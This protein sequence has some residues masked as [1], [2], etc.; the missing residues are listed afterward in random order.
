[1]KV[2]VLGGGNEIGA[3]CLHI[4]FEE[5]SI[6]IDAGMRMH[7]E[8]SL[9]MFG[10]LDELSKPDIV[11][12]THAHADHI[13]ALPVIHAMYPDVPVYSTPPTADLMQIMMKDS[14]K[15]LTEQS[16]LTESLVP[17]TEEQMNNFLQQIRVFPANGVL[18]IAGVKITSYRAGHIVGAVMF[19]IE[20]NGER[21]LVTG[22]L[23][24]N[25][26]RTIPGAKVADDIRPDVVVMESTYGNRLHTDR[27]TE[28]K[29]LAENVAATIENGG[30]ALIPAFAIG[31]AQ[32]IL[33]ILQAYMEKGLIPTFPIYVDGLVTPVCRVYKNYPHYLKGPVAHR[34]R[35]NGDAFLTEGRCIAVDSK[36]RNAIV[37]G[38]PAC[39]VAS[40]GMLTGGA[41]AW[42]ARHL[43]T[44]E[45]NAVYLTGY[46]DEESPG[47]KLLALAE[48]TENTLDIDG[49]TYQVKCRVDKFGLSAHADASE[50][51]R[52]IET[53]EPTYTLLVHGDD[54]ARI[55]LIEK[56]HP[57]FQPVLT[58]NGETY[59]FEKR[60]EK[61]GIVG[62]RY[63]RN[64]EQELLRNY[65][66]S[67]LLYK[68][69]GDQN[70]K[71][72]LCQ[73][74]HPK[75]A[76]LYCETPKGKVDKVEASSVA[77]TL[78]PWN[79]SIERYTAVA[80]EVLTFSRPYLEG[81]NWDLL[82]E[83]I[84][85]LQEI[86]QTLQVTDE[87]QQFA[88]AIA[89]QSIP[90]ECRHVDLEGRVGYRLDKKVKFKL[91]NLDLPIQA[92]KMNPNHAMDH[93]RSYFT[94]H[95]HFLRCGVQQ[96]G[97]DNPHIL[98]S[99]DFP[100]SITN[101]ERKRVIKDI[102]KRTGWD[103]VF[104]DSVRH[105]AFQPVLSSLLGSDVDMPS[106]HINQSLVVTK[107]PKPENSLEISRKFN[108][109]TGFALR[110][111]EDHDSVG[112]NSSSTE[113]FMANSD[114]EPME[115]NQ[116]IAI[117][118]QYGEKNNVKIYKTSMKKV[119]GQPLMEL[120]FISPEIAVQ[121]QDM[122]LNLSKEIGIAVQFA[123]QPKQNEIIRITNASIPPAWGM[124][125]N[126][127]VHMDKAEVSIKVTNEFTEAELAEVR[128][129][130][131]KQTGYTLQ[132]K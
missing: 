17:Y 119:N 60:K 47:K 24:F 40:S 10:M 14:Y 19:L 68:K 36:N 5:V 73:K 38:N 32:E 92:I 3:S 51:T 27:N 77:E 89:L 118:K 106:V 23:S 41:S 18:E 9:P 122:L 69:E 1:M 101:T 105:E 117:A 98:L 84:V 114:Q 50:M 111:A 37:Q 83:Y 95:S 66:G 99:F 100:Q 34:I 109:T 103:T 104:S 72:G 56:I 78:G 39:I 52:F 120:H 93:V 107:E 123:K 112:L 48:G 59:P 121:Y 42:Y 22:D 49:T 131:L 58:E 82:P 30:F 33:L 25:G 53:L 108:E 127:S 132:V 35:T 12:I 54:E 43:V 46:Q 61:K 96:N 57:R 21:I 11:I 71:F 126:P 79:L 76:T 64:R 6:L 97:T 80:F 4:Q 86:F 125:G 55:G 31:R 75:I 87:A 44:D 88:I 102:K 2:T 110:F 90:K 62:R 45:K 91:S 81:I 16:R 63:K 13:G 116:A 70:Y 67:V 130:I 29:R 26:G 20:G 128:D 65:I 28:E 124:K 115:N 129:H 8:N 7:G 94:D 113:T 74:V 15:I 85:S